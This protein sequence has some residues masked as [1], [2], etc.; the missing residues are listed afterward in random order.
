MI[1]WGTGIVGYVAESGESV[2]IPDC[3]QVCFL[4]ILFGTQLLFP[5]IYPSLHLIASAFKGLKK[6]YIIE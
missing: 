2:N 4:F 3:Y 6:Q 1:P 5:T